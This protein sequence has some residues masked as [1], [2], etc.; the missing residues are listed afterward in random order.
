MFFSHST[1]ST[2]FKSLARRENYNNVAKQISYI[3]EEQFYNVHDLLK[4]ANILPLGG[5]LK[6]FYIK[7]I[8]MLK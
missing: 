4:A 5:D 8:P 2:L 1:S 7:N 6:L 3:L